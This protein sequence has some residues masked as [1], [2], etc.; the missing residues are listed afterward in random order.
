M[1][2]IWGLVISMVGALF[3]TWGRT[4]SDFGLYRFLVA[5]SR[6]LWGDR[7][8]GFYPSRR[9]PHDHRRSGHCSDR[10]SNQEPHAEGSMLIE[11]LF[12]FLRGECNP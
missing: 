12:E 1:N 10:L 8:H 3:I 4:R 7:V 9:R 5:R 11:H 2:I 6:I